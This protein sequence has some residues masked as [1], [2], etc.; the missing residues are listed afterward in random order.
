M[1]ENSKTVGGASYCQ[2]LWIRF[3]TPF[4]KLFKFFDPV[5]PHHFSKMQLKN[6]IT[7]TD[8]SIA[9]ERFYLIRGPLLASLKMFIGR[10][11]MFH[12]SVLATKKKPEAKI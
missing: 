3:L 5:H 4:R 12:Y 7:R 8:F 9:R 2:M 11:A 1:L 10:F 6:L